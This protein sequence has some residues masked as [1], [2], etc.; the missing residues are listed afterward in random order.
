MGGETKTQ[1]ATQRQ[2]EGAVGTQTGAREEFLNDPLF[3]AIRAIAEGIVANPQ[4]FG[5][6]QREALF[7]QTAGQANQAATQASNELLAG[8]TVGSGTRSGSTTAGLFDIGA[9]LGE[10]LAQ[11][12]RQIAIQGAQQDRADENAAIGTGQNILNLQNLLNQQIANAQL[13]GATTI[14][15]TGNQQSPGAQLGGGLLGTAG[16]VLTAGT[17]S[18]GLFKG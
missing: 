9:R 10:S 1:K 2:V 16:N 8:Q 12:Q 13:G 5:P 11:S 6:A 18:K 17:S 15:A 7:R 14:A 3:G 4:T